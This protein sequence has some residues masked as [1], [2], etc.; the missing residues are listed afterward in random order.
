M[1]QKAPQQKTEYGNVTPTTTGSSEAKQFAAPEQN[2]HF[3]AQKKEMNAGGSTS[4]TA[5]A[6]HAHPHD[7]TIQQKS[8]TAPDTGINFSIQK[9][10]NKT[11]LPDQLKSGIENL[12]GVKVHLQTPKSFSVLSN[13]ESAIQRI[14]KD[15]LSRSNDLLIIQR[16]LS[17]KDNELFLKWL[18]EVK[19]PIDQTAIDRICLFSGSLEEAKE[20]AAIEDQVR[21]ESKNRRKLSSEKASK[22]VERREGKNK[23]D[24]DEWQQILADLSA[25]GLGAALPAAVTSLAEVLF[26]HYPPNGY[27]YIMMGNS[28]APLMAFLEINNIRSFHFPLG[29]I[30][31]VHQSSQQFNESVKQSEK[32]IDDYLELV[33]G[34]AVDIGKPLVLIDYVSSGSSMIL[35]MDLIKSWISKRKQKVNVDF[36]GFTNHKP[37]KLPKL[38][39]GNHSGVLATAVGKMERTFIQMMAGKDYK[40]SLML[41]GPSSMEMAKLLETKNPAA[42]MVNHVGYYKR[43]VQML[44][45]ELKR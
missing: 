5:S 27:T 3:T 26:S 41:K 14:K 35:A 10:E 7:Q 33:L 2:I 16:K 6:L 8:Q 25:P 32:L 31:D 44:L 43:L 17:E 42:A 24:M 20:Q 28:P 12:S 29:G 15:T 30:T 23:P 40:Q 37:D 4:L 22:A 19:Y 45:L 13:N 11:G 38:M 9:K 39:Q 18:S 36:F 34:K 1:K 21:K